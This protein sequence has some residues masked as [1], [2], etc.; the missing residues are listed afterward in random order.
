[1]RGL[2]MENRKIYLGIDLGTDNLGYAVTDENYKVLRKGDKNGLGVVQFSNA[3][4]AA[5][6]RINRTTSRRIARR[7]YR[8]S[9]LN[10]IFAPEIMK[11]DKNFLQRL[12][13]SDLKHEDRKVD[14]KHTLFNDAGFTDSE[15]YNK[16]PTI[17]HLRKALM[18][19][20]SDDVRLLYLAVHHIVKYRGNF[21]RSEDSIGGESDNFSLII[22]IIDELN[23]R[24]ENRNQDLIAENS[25]Y[26]A[27][28][29]SKYTVDVDE[30][31]AI[32]SGKKLDEN[33]KPIRGKDRKEAL[34][35]AFNATKGGNQIGLLD[36]SIKGKGK[37]RTIFGEYYDKESNLEIDFSQFDE[38]SGEYS[39]VVN[40]QDFAILEKM[41]ELYDWCVLTSLLAGYNLLS[42]AMIALYNRHK[43][44]LAE[45]KSLI[46]TYGDKDMFKRVF[47]L[48]ADN[49]YS[50]Y[51]GGGTYVK[52]NKE[53][54]SKEQ[55]TN[56]CSD[57]D[58]YKFL[59]KELA[60]IKNPVAQSKIKEIETKM[61]I[62]GYL[63]KPVSKNNSTLPYQLNKKE[64][65]I[66]LDNAI[67]SGK[68]DFLTKVS[69]GMSNRDKIISLLTF[70][71]PYYVGPIKQYTKEEDYKNKHGWAVHNMGTSGRITPWNFE[72]RINLVE[73]EKAFIKKMTS[74]C[75]YLKDC[76]AL[77]KNSLIYER[78]LALN[79]LNTLKIDGCPMSVE[80]KKGIFDNVYLNKKVTIKNIKE[81][82]FSIG[83]SREVRI[84]GYDKEL[85]GDM[86]VYR[87]F[88]E[89]FKDKVDLYPKLME[90]IIFILTIHE[91][92]KLIEKALRKY[93]SILSNDEI[94]KIKGYKYSGWG[95]LSGELLKGSIYEKGIQLTVRGCEL[96]DLI[97]LLYETNLNFMQLINAKEY[98]F[99]KKV[100]EYLEENELID[101]T[102][103]VYKDVEEQYCSP[104]VKRSVWQ[105][106]KVVKE[107]QKEF[108]AIPQKIFLEVT[109]TN[110]DKDKGK[111][112]R[113]RK[114]QIDAIYREAE[115][116]VKEFANMKEALQKRRNELSVYDKDKDSSELKSKK[117][118]LYF[119]QLGQDVYTGQEIEIDELYNYDIDHII[120]Q[121]K[122]KDDSLDN[123]V[124]VHKVVNNA[125]KKDLYPLPKECRQPTLWKTLLKMDLMSKEKYD[126]L[127][128]TT[129]IS[130]E[131]EK[132]FINRQLVET[133]QTAL[134]VRDLL[135]KWAR[136][137]G[138]DIEI[139][140]NR[141]G[142]VAEF[143]KMFHLTKSRDINDFHHAY[144]AYMNVVVGNVLFENFNHS[145]DYNRRIDEKEEYQDVV[146]QD[147]KKIDKKSNN[148]KRCFYRNVYSDREQRVIWYPENSKKA[149]PTIDIV[150]KSLRLIPNVTSKVET[151]KGQFYKETIFKAGDG[152]IPLKDKGPKS[153]VEGL[154]KYGGYKSS[155][156]AYFVV[157]E[158]DGN[159]GETKRYLEGVSIY[160]DMLMRKGLK[161][162]EEF[163]K[164]F[165]R[166][167]N[168]RFANIPELKEGKIKVGS[169]LRFDDEYELYL[170]GQKEKQVL[171]HN[172]NQLHTSDYINSYIKE[173]RTIVDKVVKELVSL[174]KENEEEQEEICVELVKRNLERI[175]IAKNNN[176]VYDH[177]I[178]LSKENNLAIYDYVM[179][180]LSKKPYLNIPR[181]KN[182]SS[183]LKSARELFQ[184]YALFKQIKL[185]LT[186]F[187]LFGRNKVGVDLCIMK[188]DAMKIKGSSEA[189]RICSSKELKSKV[190][191]VTKSI[192][193]LKE[194]VIIINQPK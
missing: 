30:V 41:K 68:Y 35:V 75:T 140:L 85:K 28:N 2:S 88:K 117:L 27:Y 70:R 61:D 59:K 124:L 110:S 107:L 114:E 67:A 86:K 145:R 134:I 152:L 77:P 188:D 17:Y 32:L 8:V 1:M 170:A 48:S 144:D 181:Y 138:V 36:A 96:Y 162:K 100:L 15:F 33:G 160:E 5:S 29:I 56:K 125:I 129:P 178:V 149:T 90:E 50:T 72:D 148:F 187:G 102:N 71:V 87:A 123:K 62:G 45:L 104:T 151:G 26:I 150:K 169:L 158:A 79:E 46:K 98:G 12:K 194:K 139:N 92:A 120:P 157:I 115:S 44:E 60:K 34:N 186:V 101:N 91:D 109:R 18:E 106:I 24:I 42:D 119:M 133:A 51:V 164:G 132:K 131:E 191:L 55:Y 193:G 127:T 11:V 9:L 179:E 122:V 20:A 19:K 80:V 137:Q 135:A 118:F 53:I 182:V 165:H 180:K 13:E 58:F 163:L 82:L 66:I 95:R 184:S 16:Y 154:K 37:I 89:I 141:G 99:E 128:R 190:C 105:T 76:D 174:K 111:R 21:L 81:Y 4:T 74:S 166:Y 52:E 6:R 93:S 177:I 14:F 136:S 65:E 22:N 161:T 73:S 25:E 10:D 142:N 130:E 189:G 153:G 192:T 63:P 83:Y 31:V 159:K 175:E 103:V 156:T 116:K 146:A 84:S 54:Q 47:H 147:G 64:L 23:A 49:N 183:F 3:E 78:Y 112:T 43:S 57:V 113:S 173:M 185:L 143:R 7:R 69:D 97:D 39:M 121:S 126:R 108:G 171:F 176:N 167:E 172:A 40:E 38:K 94:K 155:G 168:A